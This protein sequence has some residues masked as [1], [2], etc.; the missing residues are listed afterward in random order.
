MKISCLQVKETEKG[1]GHGGK[2]FQEAGRD[3]RACADNQLGYCFGVTL[4]N[5]PASLDGSLAPSE[6][7]IRGTSGHLDLDL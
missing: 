6:R 3:L 7:G 4:F 2:T 5:G 1:N